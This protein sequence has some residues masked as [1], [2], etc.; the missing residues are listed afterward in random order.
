MERERWGVIEGSSAV[1]KLLLLRTTLMTELNKDL[2]FALPQN[3]TFHHRLFRRSEILTL[4]RL[5]P[6]MIGVTLIVTCST[7]APASTWS[8]T[9]YL[10]HNRGRV[11]N[12]RLQKSTSS[13]Q[14]NIRGGNNGLINN[15]SRCVTRRGVSQLSELSIV[16]SPPDSTPLIA[17]LITRSS[18]YSAVGYY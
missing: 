5:T 18:L 14:E 1:T 6:F 10:L 15:I 4:C 12:K 8:E 11:D 17:H 2:A 13:C 9:T 16:L 7:S 3:Q